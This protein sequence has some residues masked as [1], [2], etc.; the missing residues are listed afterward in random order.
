MDVT[1]VAAAS[2]AGTVGGAM[3]TKLGSAIVKGVSKT[4]GG[5]WKLIWKIMKGILKVIMVIL[6]T[7]LLFF[8]KI[9]LD[10]IVGVLKALGKTGAIASKIAQWSTNAVFQNIPETANK[11][12]TSTIGKGFAVFIALC[13]LCGM[14]YM[15]YNIVVPK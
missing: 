13:I 12:A 3:I 2:A 6:I 7:V 5:F 10:L 15:I 9:V 11:W 8:A 14:A 1:T 4:K